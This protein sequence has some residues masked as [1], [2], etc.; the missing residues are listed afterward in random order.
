VPRVG[1]AL[2]LPH[3]GGVGAGQVAKAA[4]QII[5]GLNIGGVAEA[6][7]LVEAAGVDPANVRKAL[8]GGF[9]GSRILEVHGQ[10]MIGRAYLPGARI[11]T[12][13]KDMDQACDL[14]AALGQALP[15]TA[16]S[17][18]LYAQAIERGDGDL[19]HSALIRTLCHSE[20]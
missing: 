11:T 1:P 8:L 15:A 5:V 10:R 3:V 14:G 7:A 13:Y 19:D 2:D 20:D 18:S 9:A 16:L 12:Q 4:N 17:R 6:L